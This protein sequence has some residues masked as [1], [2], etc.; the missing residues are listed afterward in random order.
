M[1][2]PPPALVNERPRR[3][4][5]RFQNCWKISDKYYI[6]FSMKN[7]LLIR[8]LRKWENVPLYIEGKISAAKEGRPQRGDRKALAFLSGAGHRTPR[9]PGNLV[10][11]QA[12]SGYVLFQPASPPFQREGMCAALDYVWENAFQPTPSAER[13]TAAKLLKNHLKFQSIPSAGRVTEKPDIH[14]HYHNIYFNPRP[15]FWRGRPAAGS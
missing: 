4:A 14:R 8:T 3:S 15:L 9:L 1:N 7:Q 11:V 6:R 2:R 10:E 12:P 5:E 13:M